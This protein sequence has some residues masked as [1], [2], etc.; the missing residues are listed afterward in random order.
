MSI[1]ISRHSAGLDEMKRKDQ[2]DVQA[3]L[4]QLSTMS[5]FSCFEASENDDI[6]KTMTIICQRGY[7]EQTGGAYPW[8]EFRITESGQHIIAKGYIP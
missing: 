5:R 6:A 1:I 3:V 4:K 8:T 7:I 2:R